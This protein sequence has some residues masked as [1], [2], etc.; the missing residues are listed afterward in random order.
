MNE[1]CNCLLNYADFTSFSKV[2]TETKTNNCDIKK[3]LWKVEGE[4]IVLK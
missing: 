3:A 2:N 1:A 4:S